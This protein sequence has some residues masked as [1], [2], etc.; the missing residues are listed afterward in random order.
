MFFK[1]SEYFDFFPLVKFLI[2]FFH[3]LVAF[4]HL[5]VERSFSQTKITWQQGITP[6]KHL[7]DWEGI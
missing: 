2:S 6:Q 4:F 7:K 1:S 5:A 3:Y